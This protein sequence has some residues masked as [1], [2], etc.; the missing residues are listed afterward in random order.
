M[1]AGCA[2]DLAQIHA[3]KFASA[4]QA[5][6]NR[7]TRCG[8]GLE[9]GVE[10]HEFLFAREN[11]EHRIHRNCTEDAEKTHQEF[12]KSSHVFYSLPF[13]SFSVFSVR[14]LCFLRYLSYL[15]Q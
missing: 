2:R 3:A 6:A 10:A 4:N 8:A 15:R 1:Y 12:R 14:F 11:R 7:V 9:L 5:N 13:F